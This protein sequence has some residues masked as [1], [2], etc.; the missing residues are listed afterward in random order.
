[1]SPKENSEKNTKTS[2]INVLKFARRREDEGNENSP[3]ERRQP[4]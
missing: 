3:N 1:M 4:N 2:A